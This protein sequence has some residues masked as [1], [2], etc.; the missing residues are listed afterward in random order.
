M[1]TTF[2][3]RWERVGRKLPMPQPM[4]MTDNSLRLPVILL[5]KCQKM[6]FLTPSAN[7]LTTSSKYFL[8]ERSHTFASL[9]IMRF[10]NGEGYIKIVVAVAL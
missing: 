8:A 6:G 2:E 9:S 1:P 10:V 5:S 7:G 3:N 4:S